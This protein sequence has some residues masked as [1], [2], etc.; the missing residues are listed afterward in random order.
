MYKEGVYM[1]DLLD[2]LNVVY[3]EVTTPVLHYIINSELYGADLDGVE[4]CALFVTSNDLVKVV[5]PNY[6]DGNADD[7]FFNKYPDLSFSKAFCCKGELIGTIFTRR[8]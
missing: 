3:D 4:D 5:I 7:Y 2:N 6:S 8:K 1:K